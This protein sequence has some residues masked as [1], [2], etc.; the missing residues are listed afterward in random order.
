MMMNFRKCAALC[1][2]ASVVA[3]QANAQ[4]SSGGDWGGFHGTVYGATAF[5]S[6]SWMVST[7]DETESGNFGGFGGGVGIGYDYVANGFV[8]GAELDIGI[9]RFSSENDASS[10]FSCADETC[11][12]EVSTV[13]TLRARAGRPY[14]DWLPYVTGGLAAADVEGTAVVSGND[15]VIGE[16]RMT[17]WTLGAGIERAFTPV[18]SGKIEVLYFDLGTL[19]LP[20]TC[21]PDCETDVRFTTVRAGVS[22]NF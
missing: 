19:D 14:G 6:N 1:C 17:G 20:N 22:Y 7:G 13:A 10:S 3:F 16:D 9:A 4:Q 2:V 18:L 15:F 21:S 5:G 12:T 11:N 8:I